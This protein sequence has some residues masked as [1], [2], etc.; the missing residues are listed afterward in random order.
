[1]EIERKD[2]KTIQRGASRFVFLAAYYLSK[3]ERK[4]KS[5]GP[6]EL[7]RNIKSYRNF[8]GKTEM[9]KVTIFYFIRT[10]KD[11]DKIYSH[12]LRCMC[13]R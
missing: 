13:L 2:N 6:L 8:K 12:I 5:A 9:P 7:A 1:M 11:N 10:W 4:I 3:N